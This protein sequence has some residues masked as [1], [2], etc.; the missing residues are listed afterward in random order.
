AML[1][2]RDGSV[3][4]MNERAEFGV[5]MGRKDT[6]IQLERGNIIFRRPS[7]TPA[8]FMLPRAIAA[9]R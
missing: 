8:I 9:Y 4:E 6:T 5:S 7:V 3:V 2:L 1:R